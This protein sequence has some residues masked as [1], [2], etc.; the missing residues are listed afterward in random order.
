[1]LGSLA[2]SFTISCMCEIYV[3]TIAGFGIVNGR[4]NRTFREVVPFGNPRMSQV[5]RE[6][7]V[8][9][10]SYDGCC[11]V[12]RRSHKGQTTG[13]IEYLDYCVP[14]PSLTT[15]LQRWDYL[16]IGNR[17]K[18]GQAVERIKKPAQDAHHC[19]NRLSGAGVLIEW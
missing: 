12:I 17:I 19:R 4:S 5:T 11:L 13:V 10:F 7:G 9:C 15:H 3:R 14:H 1:M 16:T 18:F 6:Y 8:L 2:A